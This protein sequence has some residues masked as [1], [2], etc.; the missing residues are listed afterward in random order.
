[1]FRKILIVAFII[2]SGCFTLFAQNEPDTNKSKDTY[3]HHK[4]RHQER[5][6][7]WE[8]EFRGNPTLSLSYGISK[9]SM[10][11][12][13]STFAKPG[14]ME[15]KLGYTHQNSSWNSDNILDY[16]FRYFYFSNFS[17][18][19]SGNTPGAN[20]LKSNLWKFGFGKSEGY[21]YSLGR[22]AII[23]YYTYSVDW[24]KLK[25]ET[26][27]VN[28][29]D[30]ML[31]DLFNNH[32]RFGTSFEGGVRFQIIQ[33][34]SLD[35]SYQRS[36]IFPRH[37]FWKWAGSV[38]VESAGQWLLDEFVDETMNSSPYAAPIVN[39][40]LKNALAYGMYELRHD[41]MN[42]PINTVAPLSYDQLKFGVS[43]VF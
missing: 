26:D 22:A 8:N 20:E 7:F 2:L 36:I 34:V 39:F 17:A 28:S 6:R 25:M 14:M 27:P 42:W 10:K 43:F 30:K 12:F 37:L 9:I 4:Y 32:F 19:L 16:S 33:L 24:S 40:V 15:L 11:D 31:T 5:F 18:D 1:M 23:P 41:K 38:A 35:I 3:R 29:K 21:G 13:G